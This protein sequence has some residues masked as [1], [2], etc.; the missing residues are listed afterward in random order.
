M[1][2]QPHP[3]DVHV[4][5]RVRMCRTLKG[6][7]QQKLAASLGLTFQ[8]VQKYERGANRISASRLW[9]MG[10]ILDVPVSHFF[11]DADAAGVKDS[12]FGAAVAEKAVEFEPESLFRREILELVRAYDRLENPAVR[13]RIFELIKTLG[14]DAG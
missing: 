8:Q 9:E 11:E 12:R 13:K 3:V 7:S 10:Q 1:A 5:T 4:G 6:L 2:E 14:E